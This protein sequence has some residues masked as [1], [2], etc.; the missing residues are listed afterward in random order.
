MSKFF[1]LGF[2]S[3]NGLLILSVRFF[4]K[5]QIV[6]K[7]VFVASEV[8]SSGRTVVPVFEKKVSFG[9]IKSYADE[10]GLPLKKILQVAG[11]NGTPD[12][13]TSLFSPKQSS[14]KALTFWTA[15]KKKGFD[16][17]NFGAKAAA[18]FCSSG[19]SSLTLCMDGLSLSSEEI[20]KIA[21]G[22]RLATYRFFKHRTQVPANTI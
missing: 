20:A 9:A 15:G 2:T 1:S 11:S 22:A 7:V 10:F 5:R 18:A 17:E 14:S 21:V 6:V 16:A 13:Q 19:E 3:G 12:A 4:Y 8:V